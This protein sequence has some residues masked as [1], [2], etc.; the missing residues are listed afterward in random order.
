MFL[1]EYQDQIYKVPIERTTKQDNTKEKVE[2]EYEYVIRGLREDEVKEWSE[3]CASVFSYKPDPP[4]SE[5]FYRH[6]VNDPNTKAYD[7]SSRLIRVALFEGTIVASCRIFLRTITGTNG[8]LRAGGIG[9]VCT[10]MNHRRRGLSAKILENAIAIMKDRDD[11]QV[12][13]LHAAPAFFPLYESLGYSCPP[14][15]NPSGGNRWST[16]DFYWRM[17]AIK[18]DLAHHAAQSEKKIDDDKN[19]DDDDN[20]DDDDDDDNDEHGSII[21][22]SHMINDMH[23]R[24]AEFPR[25]TEKLQQLHAKYSEERFTGC[26]VRSKEY[27][28]DYLSKEL[29]GSLFVLVYPCGPFGDR[30][31]AWMS[32]K[33]LKSE[34]SLSYCIQ[35]FGMDSLYFE[36]ERLPTGWVVVCMLTHAILKLEGESSSLLLAAKAK[37]ET[38]SDMAFLLTLPGFLKDKM[39]TYRASSVLRFDWA[40]ER[41]SIDRGWMYRGLG[42]SRGNSTTNSS[43]VADGFLDFVR[44][45]AIPSEQ[46]RR[47]H[48]VWPSDSF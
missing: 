14:A 9:E 19:D 38:T 42:A 33:P 44:G 12:S 25:D 29:E 48:F 46:P 31:L 15:S 30:I 32:V 13:S 11:L 37:A 7:G 10:A 16:L 20:N 17:S 21:I 22:R 39:G 40:S 27:W 5:Y 35:E 2:N 24:P 3:F 1:I 26:I 8:V 28:N 18:G 41:T 45:I 47:E 43:T 36:E 23:L 6:Y 34:G 4:P